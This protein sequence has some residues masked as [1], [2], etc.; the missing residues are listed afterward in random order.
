MLGALSVLP[1]LAVP[2]DAAVSASVASAG[3]GSQQPSF[4][5]EPTP[6]M[7]ADLDAIVAAGMTWV[8]ADFYWSAIELQRAKFSWTATD[9]FV[10]AA[11][12]RGLQVLAMPDYTP[13]WAR[14]GP[15]DKY[16][17][18]NPADYANFVAKL[19]ARYAPMGVHAWEIWNEPNVSAFWAPKADPVAYTKLLKLAYV[20]IKH[21]DPSATVVSGGLAPATNNG[22]D[23]A[24]LTFVT[25]M[26]A[27]GAKG[28]FSALGY[29]PYSYPY[30]PMY[31]ADW[32]TFY[33][34]P[35]MHTLMAS[36]GD[37]AKRIWGTE[38]GY[39]T[40]TNPTAVSKPQQTAYTTAAV[41]QW[42]SWTF[43]GPL[44]LFS[45]RDFS[46]DARSLDDNMGMLYNSGAPKP[47]YAALKQLL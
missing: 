32:N 9:S 7:N 30:P 2:R 36:K 21:A 46:T 47:L 23:L 38:M 41:K 29:H 17:P 27:Q 24:P 1:A 43:S 22:R 37:A 15:T 34:T 16:P 25:S 42:T 3:V 14:S 20:A 18:R 26:Y 45:L 31:P 8:R 44:M 33:R 19:A 28:Y 5:W 13:A 35:A 11:R 10:R 39:P 6:R 4:A 12:S 40:G